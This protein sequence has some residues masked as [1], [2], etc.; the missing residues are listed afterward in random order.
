MGVPGRLKPRAGVP[1]LTL[2]GANPLGWSGPERKGL[3]AMKL[4]L[5]VDC[6][7][8]EARRFL[9]LPDLTP[10]HD[11]FVGRMQEFVGKGVNPAEAEAMIRSWMSAGLQ[12]LGA[13]QKAFWDAARG[14][15]AGRE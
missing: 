15:G 1:T 5:D 11:V 2:T 9:G 12:G 4:R 14:S 3:R 6:T 7:P 10:V 13:V 8:E